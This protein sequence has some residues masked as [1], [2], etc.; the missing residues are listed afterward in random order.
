MSTAPAS[1]YIYLEKETPPTI[2]Y[3][4]YARGHANTTHTNT[5]PMNLRLSLTERKLL[6]QVC[7]VSIFRIVCPCASFGAQPEIVVV[8]HHHHLLLIFSPVRI[9]RKT[10]S[11]PHPWNLR[12]ERRRQPL[13]LRPKQ[14]LR[15]KRRSN[16]QR[17]RLRPRLRLKKKR[18]SK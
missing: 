17:L 10:N 12:S 16:W 1:I 9:P 15:K 2:D 11:H 3:T 14:R 13:R 5:N 18:R 4:T 6:D 8:L 7:C